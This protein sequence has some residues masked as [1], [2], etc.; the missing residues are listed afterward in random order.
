MKQIKT[1]SQYIIAAIL[2]VLCF[3]LYWLNMGNYAFLDTDETRFV[4]IAKDM[5]NSS[6]WINVKLNGENSLSYP[7]FLFWLINLSCFAF[8]KIT[9]EVVRLPIS[10]MTSFGILL[11]F[12]L[13]KNLLSKSYA[14]II[15]IIFATSLGT[16]IFS[17][18]ATTEM[19]FCIFSMS[20]VLCAS[21]TLFSRKNKQKI[22]VWALAYLFIAF[23]TMTVGVLGFIIPSACILAMYMFSGNAK[24]LFLPKHFLFGLIIFAFITIPWHL[25]MVEKHGLLF[26][27]DYLSVCNFTKYAGAKETLKVLSIFLISFLPWAFSFLW[28][29]GTK[30]KDIISSI[31]AYF[32]DNSQVK[33]QDKWQKLKTTERFLS[34]NTIVFFTAL[35]FAILYGVK[36]TYTII[37]LLFPAS[38]ITGFYWYEYIIK[39]EHDKSI[40]FATIIPNLIL[41]ICSLVGLFGH[42]FLNTMIMESLNN[43]IVPLVTIFF[44]IPLFGIFAVILKGRIPAFCSN[45]ILMI[46]IS[47]ILTPS[48]FNFMIANGG[49][50]DLITF[51][52][53][54]KN[55]NVKLSTFLPSKKYSIAYYYDKK[56][57][58]HSN[59]DVEWLKD[60]LKN[61]PNDYVIVEIKDLN[62]IEA[63]KIPYMLINSGKRYCLIQ[64]LPS[65]LE[66]LKDEEEPQIIVY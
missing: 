42:N 46:S 34:I 23:A 50:K 65:S 54:A 57:D 38:C 55:D 17:R 2:L 16:L 27:K 21:K 59:S 33:L 63:Q 6:D 45:I 56:V 60:Y 12:F 41:I 35:I 26:V 44:L 37:F 39:K 49:E 36:C 8:G 7:P 29:I 28:I 25:I 5:L 53:L 24:E 51:A 61:N 11:L 18:L 19:L 15:T 40:F 20:A 58:F 48:F 52:N 3:L 13:L 32:K 9:N 30:A 47:L 4:T 22:I 31:H 43:L 1:H 62:E 66:H 10:L 64:H 14:F